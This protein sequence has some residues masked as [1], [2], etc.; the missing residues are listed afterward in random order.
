MSLESLRSL[1]SLGRRYQIKFKEIRVNRVN[2]VNRVDKARVSLPYLPH[3][4][5]LD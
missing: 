2:R 5:H 4:F 1:W 3:K